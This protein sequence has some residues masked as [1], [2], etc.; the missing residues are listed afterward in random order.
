MIT[1]RHEDRYRGAR[2]RVAGSVLVLLAGALL[3]AAT[4]AAPASA[5]APVWQLGT[6]A[7]PTDLP[8]GGSGLLSL[9]VSNLGDQS[10]SGGT[11]PII[12]TGTLPAGVVATGVNQTVVNESPVEC[13]AA[14][15]VKC[16][17]KGVLNPYEQ[18]VIP[19]K[20]TVQE[21]AGT[22]LLSAGANVTG[23]GGASVS[24][25]LP[26]RVGT[27]LTPFG[28]AAYQLQPLNEDGSPDTHPGHIRSS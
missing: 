12:V 2:R 7:A 19:I 25:N 13:T 16:T 17:F 1:E 5:A 28:V 9:V 15:E 4:I 18:I 24:T 8:S 22:S 11:E 26:V 21:P 20:V 27:L 14:T 3:L 6:E 23:G 10:A